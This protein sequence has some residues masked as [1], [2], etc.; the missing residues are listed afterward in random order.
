MQTMPGSEEN[1][2]VHVRVS[3]DISGESRAG[4]ERVEV[5]RKGKAQKL[6]VVERLGKDGNWMQGHEV[7]MRRAG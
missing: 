7:A 4:R 3:L 6:K 5:G 2:R 1:C